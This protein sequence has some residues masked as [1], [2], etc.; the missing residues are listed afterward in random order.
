VSAP[1]WKDPPKG[2]AFTVPG[3]KRRY[4]LLED[5]E[6]RHG[7]DRILIRAGFVWND[8]SSPR[9]MRWFIGRDEC[10]EVGPLV[11]D[12]LYAFG[13]LLPLDWCALRP[14]T[15]AEADRLFYLLMIAEGVKRWRARFAYLAVRIGGWAAWKAPQEYRRA[16]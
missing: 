14:Y 10:G 1:T 7:P 2:D 13:G 11:H 8:A 16:A 4:R 6:V 15:R 5:F 9:A 12:A 3:G